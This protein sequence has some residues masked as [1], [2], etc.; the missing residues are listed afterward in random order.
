M[1]GRDLKRW[2][3]EFADWH[4]IRIE[5]S[6]NRK[7][8]WSGLSA[9]EAERSFAR[10]FPSVRDFFHQHRQALIDRYDQGKYFWELRACAYWA[11]F[12][13][14][15]IIYPDISQIPQFSWD[16]MGYYG[17]DTTFFIRFESNHL[18]ALLNSSVTQWA[19]SQISPN[20]QNGY[21]RFKTQYC[22]QLSIP[23]ASIRQQALL[24]ALTVA[25]AGVDPRFEQLINGLVYE[26]F[27][28]DDLHAAGIRLFDACEREHITR[29]A[30]L[31]GAALQ[32]EAEALAERIFSN[33]HP[34]YAML[35]DLKALDVVRI[36][37]ARD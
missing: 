7:H 31:Q 27:F 20:V 8:L 36:I 11:E 25:R 16:S 37:E 34:I 9:R 3:I 6:E 29:L 21:F 24:S 4:L 2:R 5:S 15:K 33:H 14:P 10:A 1:R 19:L 28:P 17:A 23:A 26:L 32:T 22:E 18:V 13:Q 12:E 30:T 35:F